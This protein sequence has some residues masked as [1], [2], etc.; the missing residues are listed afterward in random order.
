MEEER[1]PRLVQ[2][3]TIEDVR[4]IKK[5]ENIS[6]DEANELLFA[7]EKLAII[8]YNTWQKTKQE[9]NEQQQL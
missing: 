2:D 3:I 6:D 5:Y 4:K 9:K 7:L 8:T 1:K